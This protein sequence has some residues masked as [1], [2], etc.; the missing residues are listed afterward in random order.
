MTARWPFDELILPAGDVTLRPVRDTDLAH[1]IAIFPD[2]FD[3]DPAFPPLPAMP[4]GQDRERRL[5]QSIWRH[6]GCWSIDDWALDFGV[7]RGGE[8][9]GIQTLEGTDFPTER[10]VDT[11][12]WIAKPLRGKG[13]GVHAREVVLAFAF[14]QL[15]AAHAITSAVTTNQASLGVSRHLGYRDDGVR[16]HDT[17]DGIVD[18]QH[19]TLSVDDWS[20][21]TN[22]LAIDVSGFDECAAFF[23]RA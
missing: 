4:P 8:P 18:L 15:K 3:L 13:F 10:T 20:A 11:S 6:R 21:G 19:L 7:W 12:S 2:D 17:G 9:I 22:R 16:P 23:G 5:A 1:F 14:D